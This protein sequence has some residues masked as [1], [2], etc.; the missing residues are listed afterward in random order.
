MTLPLA[1]FPVNVYK[2][3]LIFIKVTIVAMGCV[4]TDFTMIEL[5]IPDRDSTIRFEYFYLHVRY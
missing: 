1:P 5:C 2:D 4:T 3:T